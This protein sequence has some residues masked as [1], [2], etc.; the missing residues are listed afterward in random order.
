MARLR[1]FGLRLGDQEHYLLDALS[2]RLERS[3]SDVVRRLI[4]QAARENGVEAK[5]QSTL[6]E[7]PAG[8]SGDVR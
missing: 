3:R 7:P 8:Q 5:P 4:L 1:N 2:N 6:V